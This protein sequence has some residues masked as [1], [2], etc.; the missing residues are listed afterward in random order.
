[1]ADVNHYSVF[2]PSGVVG[3]GPAYQLDE[4]NC[5]NETTLDTDKVKVMFD[6]RGIMDATDMVEASLARPDFDKSDFE[7]AYQNFDN[8]AP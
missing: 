5:W 8:L 7:T 2:Y 3:V 1:M 4:I 6:P